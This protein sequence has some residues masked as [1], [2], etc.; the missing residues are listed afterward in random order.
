MKIVSPT[1]Q[2]IKDVVKLRDRRGRTKAGLTVIEGIREVR[3]AIKAGALLQEVYLCP[4]LIE[5]Q[6]KANIQVEILKP[7]AARKVDVIEVAPEVFEKM[8]FGD[9]REGVLAVGEPLFTTLKDLKVPK[10]GLFLVIEHVEKPGNLGAIL[11][12]CDAVGIDALLVCDPAT[13]IF[14]PNVIR[15]SLGTVFQ[16]PVVNLTNEEALAFLKQV[17]ARIVAATPA[18][19]K[20]YTAVDYQGTVAM[21]AG[22]EKDGLSDFWLKAADEKVSIPM[23]GEADSLNT[24]VAAA[25]ICYE[26]LRQRA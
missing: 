13:D 18:G 8:S 6:S 14:N 3:S 26:A 10:Q 23:K 5:G 12:T 17:G 21:A 9:R 2:K 15:A 4:E 11:R 7:L 19:K 22:S 20:I 25:V 24:S 1:N 16:V